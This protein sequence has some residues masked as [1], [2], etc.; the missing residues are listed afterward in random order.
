M[1]FRSRDLREHLAPLTG[2]TPDSWTQGRLTYQLRRLRLH[3][4]IE[5]TIGTH[6][7]EVTA[8]GLR[9]AC[10]FTRSYARVIRPG[11]SDLLSENPLPSRPLNRA[12][13][14]IDQAF[15]DYVATAKI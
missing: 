3:G 5:R 8:R 6:R 4:L 7:Y 2:E 12:I 9:I 10:F 13:N 15:D 1:G 14:R 11:L